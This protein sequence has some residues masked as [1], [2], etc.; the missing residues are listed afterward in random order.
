[1]S[2]P[3]PRQ[4]RVQYDNDMLGRLMARNGHLLRMLILSRRF[5]DKLDLK[6]L[7]TSELSALQ[8]LNREIELYHK[9]R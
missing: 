7:T 3:V 9:D 5:L 4:S 1:M 8:T 6:K 2:S